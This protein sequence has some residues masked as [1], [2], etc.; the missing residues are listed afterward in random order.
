MKKI[1]ILTCLRA[2]SVCTG[3]GCLDACQA[4]SDAFARYAGEDLQ[5][6]AFFHCNGCDAPPADIHGAD[7]GMEEKLDR[8]VRIGVE[9]VHLGVCTRSCAPPHPR[10]PVIERICRTLDQRGISIVDGTHRSTK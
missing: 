2:C 5:L 10:C 4:R 3:A 8:L 7:P 6:A 1:A 9:V